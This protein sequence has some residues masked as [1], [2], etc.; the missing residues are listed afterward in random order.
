MKAYKCDRCGGLIEI[1]ERKELFNKYPTLYVD[2]ENDVS[3]LVDLCTSCSKSLNDWLYNKE[4][5]KKTTFGESVILDEAIDPCDT[6]LLSARKCEQCDYGYI[7]EE[8]RKKKYAEKH[9]IKI[10]D[11]HEEEK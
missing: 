5:E 9:G 4:T 1:E 7:S 11:P 2:D 3:Q 10:S 8:I 6:C